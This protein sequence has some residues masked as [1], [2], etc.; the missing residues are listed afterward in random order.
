MNLDDA[1]KILSD[2]V[3]LYAQENP[4]KKNEIFDALSLFQDLTGTALNLASE[5]NKSIQECLTLMARCRKAT[6]QTF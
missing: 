5:S 2:A 4:D 1:E 3:T 6:S